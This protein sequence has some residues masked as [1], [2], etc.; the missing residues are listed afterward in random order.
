MSSAPAVDDTL[1]IMC[2]NLRDIPMLKLK[3]LTVAQIKNQLCCR[4]RGRVTE[5]GVGVLSG[6]Y[7]T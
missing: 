7:L 1:R 5:W 6:I 4:E 3:S 2:M